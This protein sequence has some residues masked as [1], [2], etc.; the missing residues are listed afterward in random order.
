MHPQVPSRVFTYVEK[1]P[2]H[3]AYVIGPLDRWL[4]IAIEKTP[5]L[6]RFQFI[7]I[8]HW[9]FL[10]IY[11]FIFIY[12]LFFLDIFLYFVRFQAVCLICSTLNNI[13]SLQ[14]YSICGILSQITRFVAWPLQFRSFFD[15]LFISAF[16]KSVL[17]FFFSSNCGGGGGATKNNEITVV[18]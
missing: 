18:Q 3:T 8:F 5:T 10:L 15:M 13:F 9:P 2:F 1:Y 4:H 12:F 11:L 14:I 7:F 17:F 6:I 16:K